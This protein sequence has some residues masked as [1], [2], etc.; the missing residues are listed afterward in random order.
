M[1]G[2]PADRFHVEPKRQLLVATPASAEWDLTT[3]ILN[4]SAE[5]FLDLV[6][7]ENECILR[8]A[9]NSSNEDIISPRWQRR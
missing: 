3:T 8:I 1:I 6:L 4:P 7:H 2:K 9:P 5:R